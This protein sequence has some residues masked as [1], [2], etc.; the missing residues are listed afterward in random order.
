MTSPNGTASEPTLSDARA[1]KPSTITDA[2]SPA[3]RARC[4]RSG[5]ARTALATCEVEET[6]PGPATGA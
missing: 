6:G 4:V 5:T 1:Q 3:V 2:T